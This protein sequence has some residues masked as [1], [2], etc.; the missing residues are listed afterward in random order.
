MCQGK[1]LLYKSDLETKKLKYFPTL[2][3]YKADADTTS[4]V[5]FVE[6]LDDEFKTRFKVFESEFESCDSLLPPYRIQITNRISTNLIYHF[7]IKEVPT[8]N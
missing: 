1:L 6:N 5:N 3:A 8:S 4:F 2:K 7:R